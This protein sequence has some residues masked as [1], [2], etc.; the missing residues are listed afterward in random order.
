MLASAV[1]LLVL[2]F[3]AWEQESTSG[4]ATAPE[5]TVSPTSNNANND[6]IVFGRG[7]D[8]GS[9]DLFMMRPDGTA[10]TQL[11]N[12]SLSESSPAWSADETKIAFV[13]APARTVDFD[14]HVMNTDGSNSQQLTTSPASESDPA[15]SPDGS[16]IAF[17]RDLPIRENEI[18]SK[19]FVMNADGSNQVQLRSE[20]TFSESHPTW[21]PDGSKIAFVGVG[22]VDGGEEI[23][24]MNADGTGLK[25]LTESIFVTRQSLDWSPDGSKIVFGAFESAPPGSET[26]STSSK[27][28]IFVIN[29]DGLRVDKPHQ[30]TERPRHRSGMVS[31]WQRDSLC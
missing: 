9:S 29:A 28:D 27:Y 6:M 18:L 14:I 10:T 4:P 21:S 8:G 19:I 16:K 25:Q 15:W 22:G 12:T 31:G 1:F 30:P 26:D 7:P 11:T 2:V 17:V 13:G 3:P 24:T 20:T 23:Y 5:Q